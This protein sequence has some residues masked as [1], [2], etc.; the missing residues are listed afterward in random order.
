[1]QARIRTSARP[2]RGFL[3]SEPASANPVFGCHG[4][5]NE[6]HY[7]AAPDQGS[8]FLAQNREIAERE[9]FIAREC[10][11][12][13]CGRLFRRPRP[14]SGIKIPRDFW[15]C[16]NASEERQ[17]VRDYPPQHEA[18]RLQSMCAVRKGHFGV[19]WSSSPIRIQSTANTPLLAERRYSQM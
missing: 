10:V 6:V 17:I 12:Q 11:P 5:D 8:V 14:A 13:K 15:E 18:S 2:S 19:A 3:P 9:L 16:V 4:V 7:A 1:S